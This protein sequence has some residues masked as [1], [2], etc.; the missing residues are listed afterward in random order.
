MED[1]GRRSSAAGFPQLN[2]PGLRDLYNRVPLLGRLLDRGLLP[3]RSPERRW[4]PGKALEPPRACELI[5]HLG[6]V[7]RRVTNHFF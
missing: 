4:R 7:Q 5:L 1:R 3:R 2:R 6:D